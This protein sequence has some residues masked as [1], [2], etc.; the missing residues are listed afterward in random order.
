MYAAEIAPSD[1]KPRDIL[2]TRGRP[3]SLSEVEIVAAA[4]RLT[5][6]VGLDNLSMRAL[7]RELGVPPMTIYHYVP[8]IEALQELVVNHILQ[9][10]HIPGPD[11]GTW[12]ERLRQLE[13][14]ARRAFVDH[15]GVAARV[16]AGASEGTRLAEGVLAI[17][18]DGGFSPEAAVLCFATL[19]TFMTGQ[20]DLDAMAD[21]IV[22][23]SPITT[24]QGV[25][26]F[27][28]LT[29]DELFEFG[30]GAVIEGLKVT[31]LD[32]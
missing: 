12:D 3:P 22:S 5:R 15:P 30:F 9:E 32:P 25:I 19:Y 16:G 14:E 13:R 11:E 17:L 2:R 29:R 26:L 21:T 10:I 4:L 18:S 20:I 27:T 7:A 1:P 6:E 24:L 23:G 28:P 8:S 31:L